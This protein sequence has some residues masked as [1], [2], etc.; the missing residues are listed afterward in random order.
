MSTSRLLQPPS[1]SMSPQTQ[2][3]FVEKQESLYSTLQELAA[4][5][6]LSTTGGC[7]DPPQFHQQ[8]QKF[9]QKTSQPQSLQLYKQKEN[10]PQIN[11]Y[12][13]DMVGGMSDSKSL[14]SNNSSEL[15]D[16]VIMSRLRK[17]LEQK[18]E[19]LRR[20][21]QAFGYSLSPN[22]Q[23]MSVQQPVQTQK[24][25]QQEFP[26]HREFYARPN[27]L[28]PMWPPSEFNS[29]LGQPKLTITSTS[30]QDLSTSSSTLMG[31]SSSPSYNSRLSNQLALREQFFNSPYS[32]PSST[33]SLVKSASPTPMY[34]STP[35]S[36]HLL[37]QTNQAISGS[38]GNII[39]KSISSSY[40]T[41][42]MDSIEKRMSASP[43]PVSTS[44][45]SSSVPVYK[46][47][48]NLTKQ[49]ESGRPLSPDGFT[50]R[51]ALYKSELS[52]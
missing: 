27:R 51:T 45:N 40:N 30:S 19:F 32:P 21:S 11:L 12:G 37:E 46:I 49:F 4:S 48:D 29:N 44:T 15:S 10:I 7:V 52:R 2:Q 3:S 42:M 33:F 18:E 31:A 5:R 17:S 26:Q 9:L 50:D 38:A 39:E 23:M 47:V 16:S 36:P 20:P 25:Q 6:N 28:K 1:L 13:V 34:S 14:L 43:S 24:P 41:A 8:P 22:T 35:T